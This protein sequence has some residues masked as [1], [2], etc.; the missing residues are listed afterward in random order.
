MQAA[1]DQPA[2]S[3]L[4][5]LEFCVKPIRQGDAFALADMEESLTASEV[6][7]VA[8]PTADYE[9]LCPIRAVL[10]YKLADSLQL[11]A[12]VECGCGLFLTSDHSLSGFQDHC[13]GA[14]VR[15]CQMGS[16]E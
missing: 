11:A 9:R 2:I 16:W 12:V 6:V 10:N 14:S 5:G 4:T 13:L 7:R 15:A 8:M 1:G 3:T